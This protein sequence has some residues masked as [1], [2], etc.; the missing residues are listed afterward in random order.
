MYKVEKYIM[1]T[2]TIMA[3]RQHQGEKQRGSEGGERCSECIKATKNKKSN[4][5]A[6]LNN[7]TSAP[8]MSTEGHKL[9]Q[10][11]NHTNEQKRQERKL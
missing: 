8:N 7:Q 9:Q 5:G 1:F 2:K 4:G 10:K 3:C 6:K 11:N